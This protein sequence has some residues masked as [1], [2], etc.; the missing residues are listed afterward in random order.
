[1]GDNPGFRVT[2]Q[3][4]TEQY[5]QNGQ[6]E[7]VVRV[8]FVTDNGTPGMIAFPEARY[9]LPNVLATIGAFVEHEQQIGAIGNG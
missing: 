4:H 8:Y 5:M 2:R 9:N 1:M 6:F 7:P 3:E